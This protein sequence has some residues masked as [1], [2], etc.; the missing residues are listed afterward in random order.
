M[1]ILPPQA[2]ADLPLYSLPAA[3]AAL[4]QRPQRKARANK[5]IVGESCLILPLLLCCSAR[6]PESAARSPAKF[7]GGIG[8]GKESAMFEI[9]SRSDIGAGSIFIGVSVESADL[10]GQRLQDL[11]ASKTARQKLPQPTTVILAQRIIQDAFNFLASFSGSADT[12]RADVEVVP[13]KAF[14]DWW[15]KFES[16]LR[17]DPDFLQRQL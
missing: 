3:S 5:I 8:P 13:L 6:D 12:G 14:E 7:L 16:R 2:L 17:S 11:S 15:R 9:G 1:M 4:Q 10:V